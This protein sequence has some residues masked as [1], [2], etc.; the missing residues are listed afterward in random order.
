MKKLLILIVSAAIY[1]HFF[2]HPELAAFY[3]QQKNALLTKMSQSSKVTFKQNMNAIYND[4]KSNYISFSSSELARLKEVTAS[5][6]S[7]ESFHQV[8]CK[9]GK[10]N[11]NFHP[12]NID[13]ICPKMAKFLSSL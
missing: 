1:L 12:D 13:K 8:Y 11:K 5:V 9:Q 7:I 3:E 4:I 10:A 2:P 6:E